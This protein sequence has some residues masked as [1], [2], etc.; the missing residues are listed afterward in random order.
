MLEESQ[1]EYD[2]LG[3]GVY[4]WEADPWRALDF[5]KEAMSKG[6]MTK[7]PITDPY[8]VGAVIDL[9]ICCN[10]LEIEA[11]NELGKAYDEL[12]EALDLARQ[13]LP[14]NK[15]AR[16]NLDRAVVEYMHHSR[17]RGMLVGRKLVKLPP[18]DTVRAAFPEG[19]ELYEDAGFRRKN[20]IQI[21]VRE[22]KCIKGYF[23]LPGL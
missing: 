20:H 2:W 18:Y 23:R 15:G 12:K 6:Y 5:A 3:S 22:P 13:S 21:A 7:R 16:R 1:N 4:F 11:I 8:V 14:T 10:L 9:G 17:E 19:E